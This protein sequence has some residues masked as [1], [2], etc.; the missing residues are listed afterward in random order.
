MDLAADST[1]SESIRAIAS[2]QGLKDGTYSML[3][4]L[5]EMQ[6]CFGLICYQVN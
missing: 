3:D 5:K 6:A 4:V 1:P 2:A